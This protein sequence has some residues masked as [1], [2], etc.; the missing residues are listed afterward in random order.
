MD[1][2]LSR[3]DPETDWERMVSLYVSHC[4]PEFALAV[5]IYPGTMR[6]MQPGFGAATLAHTAK[7]ETRPHR[8]FQDGNDF[9]MAWM[10]EGLSSPA[11]REAAE[12]LNRIHLSVARR[13]PHLPGNFDD[14]DDFVY[15]LVLLA[16]FG[17]RLM[18][19]LGLPGM[20]DHMKTAWHLWARALFR[21]LRR[22][23]GP[24]ADETFPEN[25]DAMIAFALDFES[26]PYEPTRSGHQ[27]AT[28]LLGFFSTHWFPAPLRPFARDL[29]R[30]LASERV[31]RLHRIGWM[32]PRRERLV[33]VALRSA[34]TARRL[35]PDYRTPLPERLRRSRRTSS[36]LRELEPYGA[37]RGAECRRPT[38]TARRPRRRHR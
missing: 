24:L 5:M 26:R 20:G 9:L 29:T 32:S 35:L 22:E 37:P 4:V 21:L 34:F 33:R 14:T 6:M 13:T 38:G 28:A 2:E 18:T 27:V 36:Q 11:G 12:R 19:S 17:D 30:Y 15:P 10:V 1:R 16:T 25:W 8:R 23:S 31:C 3:M 7:L